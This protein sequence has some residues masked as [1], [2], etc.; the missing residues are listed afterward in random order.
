MGFPSLL[1]AGCRSPPPLVSDFRS[2]HS[3]AGPVK[4]GCPRA[5]PPPT[6]P[7]R[8]PPRPQ[9]PP[10]SS[11]FHMEASQFPWPGSMWYDR[12]KVGLTVL[13]TTSYSS[14]SA[15]RQSK[16]PRAACLEAA[17]GRETGQ[18]RVGGSSPAPQQE[19]WRQRPACT[20][21]EVSW[22]GPPPWPHPAPPFV[23]E[24]RQTR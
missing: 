21:L 11:H 9:L 6:A 19:Q 13:T 5:P 17:S 2:S 4:P 23:D 20:I 14:T 7:S 15:R 3:P 18:G 12:T 16:K 24:D 8:C 10:E 1:L 22:K